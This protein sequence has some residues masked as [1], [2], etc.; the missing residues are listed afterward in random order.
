MQEIDRSE[1]IESN[2]ALVSSSSTGDES[3]AR[4]IKY[5]MQRMDGVIPYGYSCA[6]NYLVMPS[7]PPV[8][9]SKLVVVCSEQRLA[10]FADGF[11][12]RIYI[13]SWS[14]LCRSDAVEIQF[15][16]WIGISYGEM[17]RVLFDY[18]I[19]MDPFWNG[20]FFKI[21]SI[22]IY[23]SKAASLLNFRQLR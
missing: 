15:S 13:Y 5:L 17:E 4:P 23:W 16:R 11:N 14:R 22:A 6:F 20:N 1:T 7:D 3:L 2:F 9:D 21:T 8:G 10:K 12:L 19:Q 18:T